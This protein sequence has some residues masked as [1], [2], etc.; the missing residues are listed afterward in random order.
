MR[1]VLI[2]IIAAAIFASVFAVGCLASENSYDP[3]I[4][5]DVDGDEAV[6]VVDATFIQR[7]ATHIKINISESQ[8]MHGDIDGDG[9]VSAV[10]A[11]FIQ[12]Y[13]THIATT[14]P[15]GEWVYPQQPTEEPTAAPTQAPTQK[16]TRDNDELPFVP[17]R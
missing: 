7:Y 8:L 13:S 10:D 2:F 11:T 6:D 1:K 4:L 5:G 15:I 16:P 14:Y 9:D 17:L 12:R 3:Y